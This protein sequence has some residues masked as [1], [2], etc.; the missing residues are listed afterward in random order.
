MRS[1]TNMRLYLLGWLGAVAITACG[2][3]STTADTG[4]AFT[5]QQCAQHTACDGETQCATGTC[6]SVPDCGTPICVDTDEACETVCGSVERCVILESYPVQIACE[7]SESGDGN[8]GPGVGNT[9]GGPGSGTRT[10]EDVQSD[11]QAEL[12]TI[13]ACT[14]DAE[15][16]QVLEATSCGCTRDLV[17]RNDADP[18]KFRALLSEEIDGELCVGLSST[19]DCPIADGFACVGGACSW[20]YLGGN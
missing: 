2:G 9:G 19:C 12:A 18:S 3:S 6:A 8:G 1:A 17:A 16:G 11:V 7:D 4:S 20:N 14:I 13:Q 5:A 10:C 15:C